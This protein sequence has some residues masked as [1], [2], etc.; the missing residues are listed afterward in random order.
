M[1]LTIFWKRSENYFDTINN[2]LYR[3]EKNVM[4]K[5]IITSAIILFII[6]YGIIYIISNLESADTIIEKEN[7]P[8]TNSGVN[9]DK[10]P[11]AFIL[12]PFPSLD[13]TLS[14]FIQYMKLVNLAM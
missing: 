1:F 13:G 9:A 11:I 5:Y 2:Y 4:K 3:L 6:C 8:G 12:S 10:T 14:A 7:V